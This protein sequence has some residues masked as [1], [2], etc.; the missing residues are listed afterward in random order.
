MPES[1]AELRRNK[2]RYLIF[3][4]MAAGLYAQPQQGDTLDFPCKLS[5]FKVT[6]ARTL[7]LRCNAKVPD[8][9]VIDQLTVYEVLDESI[10]HNEMSFALGA[11]RVTFAERERILK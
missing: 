11:V 5:D 2:M 1:P 10:V 9:L 6:D 8:N 7:L 4:A 3:M